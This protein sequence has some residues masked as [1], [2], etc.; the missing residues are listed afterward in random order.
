[1]NANLRPR[2]L[3]PTAE[4]LAAWLL[5]VF[6]VARVVGGG[7]P[8]LPQLIAVRVSETP[9]TWAEYRP[10]EMIT[11]NYEPVVHGDD[12]IRTVKSME[13]KL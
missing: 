6:G 11:M 7:R 1:V 3:Q 10:N 5:N 12:I 2:S 9:K 8:D 13:G 4:N